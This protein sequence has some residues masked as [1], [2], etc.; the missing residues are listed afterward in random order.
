MQAEPASDPL[1][2]TPPLHVIEYGMFS[3]GGTV[4]FEI[5][6]SRGISV[7]GC[8]D[9]RMGPVD[10]ITPA[11]CYIGAQHPT[12]PGARALPLWSKE[13]RLLIRLLDAAL[14]NDLGPER[15]RSL[16]AV[17]NPGSEINGE[18]DRGLCYILHALEYRKGLLRA[19]DSGLPECRDCMTEWVG[20]KGPVRVASI[21]RSSD[22]YDVA[23]RDS[24]G[25]TFSVSLPADTTNV[26]SSKFHDPM[27]VQFPL[28][29]LGDRCILTTIVTATPPADRTLYDALLAT[30]HARIRRTFATDGNR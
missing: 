10:T 1:N 28:G 9:G 7:V 19:V 13:E 6:D 5:V 30:V 24:T 14:D 2:L 26:G 11:H 16:A 22:D 25:N 8:F 23:M 27:V 12:Q 17:K 20:S 15:R 4:P 21:K 29:S 18:R 3:D